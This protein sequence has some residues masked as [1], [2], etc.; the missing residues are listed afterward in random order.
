MRL[1]R[2]AGGSLQLLLAA[3]LQLTLFSSLATAQRVRVCGTPEMSFSA[4]QQIQKD[5]NATME[6]MVGTTNQTLAGQRLAAMSTSFD[7][8]NARTAS[9]KPATGINVKIYFHVL[10]SGTAASQGN[11]PD[12][13]IAKQIQVGTCHSLCR[14][15]ACR[16]LSL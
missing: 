14:L 6:A 3:T 7:A 16:R 10:R 15:S 2:R 4:A 5:L 12:S 13:Q 9:A 8:A 1:S 11:V